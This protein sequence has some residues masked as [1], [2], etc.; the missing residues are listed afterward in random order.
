MNN[1]T[2]Q[3]FLVQNVECLAGPYYWHMI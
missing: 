1:T 2:T 3:H